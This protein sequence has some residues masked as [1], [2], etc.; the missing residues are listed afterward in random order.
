MKTIIELKISCKKDWEKI[1]LILFSSPSF[2]ISFANLITVFPD[3]KLKIKLINET[4]EIA[5]VICPKLIKPI[6]LIV[7]IVV[8]SEKKEDKKPPEANLT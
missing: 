4:T 3:W 1:W 5:K 8:N 7:I 2:L 6:E